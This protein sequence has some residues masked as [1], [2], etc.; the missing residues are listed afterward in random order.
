MLFATHPQTQGEYQDAAHE[1]GA[2]HQGAA[3]ADLFMRYVEQ[4]STTLKTVL[5][6]LTTLAPAGREEFRRRVDSIRKERN[7]FVLDH[8]GMP[9][10]DR[11]KKVNQSA[12][13]RLSE[14]VSFSKAIDLQYMPDWEQSYHV[15][16]TDARMVLEANASGAKRGRKA[17]TEIEKAKEFLAKLALTG[18]E[19]AA[20]ILFIQEG[21]TDAEEAPL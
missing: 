17:K 21:R 2:S 16:V 15:I 13:V 3:L 1:T 14:A 19:E 4:Q 7:K 9:E 5:R 6:D 11:L 12:S 10:H 20:L 18:E 8:K